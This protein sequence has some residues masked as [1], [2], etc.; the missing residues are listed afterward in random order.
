MS[1]ITTEARELLTRSGPHRGGF[2]GATPAASRR[3]LALRL[4]GD[5][6]GR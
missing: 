5:E 4:P 6:E 1:T 2:H 3:G